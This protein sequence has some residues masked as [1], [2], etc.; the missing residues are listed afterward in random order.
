[1]LR[2]MSKKQWSYTSKWLGRPQNF[3][4][5]A[6]DLLVTLGVTRMN[7]GNKWDVVAKKLWDSMVRLYKRLLQYWGEAGRHGAWPVYTLE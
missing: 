2:C 5:V 7:L 4:T 3:R 1:M 6:K